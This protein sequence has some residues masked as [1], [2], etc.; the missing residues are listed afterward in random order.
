MLG[1]GGVLF[2][3]TK[4]PAAA[5]PV[6]RLLPPG[7]L[8]D[9]LRVGTAARLRAAR[10]VT[11]SALVVWAAAG[12]AAGRCAPSVGSSGPLPRPTAALPGPPV[13]LHAV[14]PSAL[15]LTGIISV[16]L[17]AGLAAGSSARPA[18]AAVTGLRLWSA[19]AL[20]VAV[21][22]R[23]AGWPARCGRMAAQAGLAR[24]SPS[25]SRSA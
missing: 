13:P 22:R 5:R 19:A 11:C 1:I 3:L 6:L 15:V 21:V 2:P 24:T 7:A 23:P 9:G 14:P 16:Q 25:S 10:G 20:I 8:S 18:P 12:I 17:G 4:F